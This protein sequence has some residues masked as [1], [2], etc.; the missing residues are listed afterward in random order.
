ML[1]NVSKLRD[2]FYSVGGIKIDSAEA[3]GQNDKCWRLL[4]QA[5]FPAYARYGPLGESY[6]Q[7]IDAEYAFFGDRL[8]HFGAAGS[9]FW[10]AADHAEDALPHHGLYLRDSGCSRD[11]R[12]LQRMED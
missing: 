1:L 8:P 2:P 9:F 10:P 12:R 6:N 7:R 11:T 5:I 3:S 4:D